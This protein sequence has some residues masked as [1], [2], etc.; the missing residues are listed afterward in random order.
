VLRPSVR[1]LVATAGVLGI[2]ALLARSAGERYGRPGLPTARA[3][4]V[5][6]PD[7]V[8][9][10][11]V[12]SDEHVGMYDLRL[13]RDTVENDRIVDISM[14]GHRIFAVRAADARLELVGK[15]IT[16]DG[17]PDAVLQ[18][19]SGGMHCCSQATVLSLGDSLTSVA[20]IDGADGDI[21][22]DDLDDDG[23]PEVKLNDFRFAY[24]REYAFAETPAP[25]VI[26]RFRDGT[27]EPAC[28]LMHVA[29]PSAAYLRR[30][31]RELTD[32]WTAGDPPAT[33]W[34]YA[35]ELIYGGQADI[36][37]RWL[38]ES[39]PASVDGRDAFLAALRDRLRGSP[40]WSPPP[41]P[42]PAT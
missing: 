26:L 15:D 31:A 8:I 32:G 1:T 42:Q 27:Y 12:L 30:R 16:G 28:D 35:L 37:W 23:V 29:A 36:A 21:V 7:S 13:I 24:W 33:W 11:P 20:T 6:P 41:E 14:R 40:C 25:D 18:T 5:L 10:G 22:F 4:R 19:Y 38:K 39:W 3:I 34:G 9:A 2:A 17:I